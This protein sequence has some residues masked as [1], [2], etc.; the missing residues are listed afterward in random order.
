MLP[1]VT[2]VTELH[3][4]SNHATAGQV[5]LAK[6]V[7]RHNQTSTSSASPRVLL[8]GIADAA[9]CEL[10]R[11]LS[12]SGCRLLL[13]AV[14]ETAQVS[15]IIEQVEDSGHLLGYCVGSIDTAGH[16]MRFAADAAAAAGS[17]DLVVNF[18]ALDAEQI[19]EAFEHPDRLEVCLCEL[20]RAAISLTHVTANRMGLTWRDG[21]ILNVASVDGL[22]V[23]HSEL[24]MSL[25]R[26]PLSVATRRLAES[27]IDRNIRI[28][29][30]APSGRRWEPEARAAALTILLDDMRSGASATLSGCVF[31]L[32]LVSDRC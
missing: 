20:L 23:R 11:S 16:A 25:L 21:V 2:Q 29:A 8:T 6:A 28:N 30:V 15:R 9:A 5:V 13:Q 27:W 32:D 14:E 18:I 12:Q 7:Q 24:M 19:A 17:L 4:V 22:E 10:A 1:R 3:P 26:T 31:D